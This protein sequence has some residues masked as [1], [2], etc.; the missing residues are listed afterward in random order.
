MGETLIRKATLDDVNLLIPCLARAFDD[1]PMVNWYIRRD[2]KRADAF[3][4]LFRACLCTLSLPHGEVLTTEDCLGGALWYPPGKSKIG[5]MQM[6]TSFRTIIRV[7]S[8]R[9]LKRLLDILSTVEKV[10]PTEKHYY[11]QFLG[12]DPEHQGKGLGSALMHPVLEQ[13]DREGCGAYLENS[14]EDNL[15]FYER[16]G[17]EVTSEIDLGQEAPPV[18]AMWRD[19]KKSS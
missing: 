18:W 19:P 14:K 11:L 8:L 7:A 5:F 17:F 10:H 15:A 1:D 2:D 4:A 13:C 6:L 12:V 3:D 9:G 16:R